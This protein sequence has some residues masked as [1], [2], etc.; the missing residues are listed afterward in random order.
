MQLQGLTNQPVSQQNE[1]S[2]NHVF[3]NNNCRMEQ[4]IAIDCE[5]FFS[6]TASTCFAILMSIPTPMQSSGTDSK[7]YPTAWVNDK[8]AILYK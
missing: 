5:N 4:W 2:S 3:K 6:I 7:M 1:A 8:S